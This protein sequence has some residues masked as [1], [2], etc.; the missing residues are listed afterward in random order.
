M[1][2]YQRWNLM[3]R[4]QLSIGWTHRKSQGPSQ[5]G[6]LSACLIACG[7]ESSHNL[8]MGFFSALKKF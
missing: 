5:C 2:V 4:N 1:P 7:W 8:G 6:S 3:A